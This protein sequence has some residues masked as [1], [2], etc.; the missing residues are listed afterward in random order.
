MSNPEAR[1]NISNKLLGEKNHFYNKKH[2][3]N[4]K[5]KIRNKCVI[6]FSGNKNP[7]YG[8]TVYSIWVKKYGID[9]ANEKL[10]SYKNKLSKRFSGT[11]NPMYGKL[12]PQGSGNGWSG[13]Y[14]G[15]FFR[16]LME[17]TYMIKFI[18]KNNWIWESGETERYNIKYLDYRGNERTYHPDFIIN[19]KIMVEIKPIK[20]WNSDGVQR[21]K[22]AAEL[23]CVKHGMIYELINIDEIIDINELINKKLLT[24]TKKYSEKFKLLI[25]KQNQ[26]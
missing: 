22:N 25:E 13:W 8:K 1:K 6:L 7:M 24:F 26:Y 19:N 2:S 20:L 14:N 23:Y 10:L 18:E 11:N 4:S 21:K 15:W 17:L 16:S 5:N 3:E 9:V 12:S